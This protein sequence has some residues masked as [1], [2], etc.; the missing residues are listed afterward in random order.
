LGGGATANRRISGGSIV[1]EEQC[2]AAAAAKILLAAIA[3]TARFL[4]PVFARNFW[5]AAE[6][7][8]IRADCDPFTFSITNWMTCAAGGKRVAAGRDE[9]EFAAQPPHAGFGYFA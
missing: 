9:Q 3:S 5:K 8:Q 2:L 1:R 6:C 7:S 4:H